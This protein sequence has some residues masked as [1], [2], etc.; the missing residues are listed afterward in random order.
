MPWLRASENRDAGRPCGTHD[1]ALKIVGDG[2]SRLEALDKML[3]A[4]TPDAAATTAAKEFGGNV[5]GACHEVLRE[6][7]AQTGFK[8]REGTN[9]F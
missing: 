9:P 5:C 7:D 1:E 8:F 2:L 3:G 4:P 6:G